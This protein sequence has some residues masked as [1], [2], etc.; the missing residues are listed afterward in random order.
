MDFAVRVFI[1]M[2]FSYV[3]SMGFAI[4]INVPRRA[5]NLSGVI[6]L[7]GWMIYWFTIHAG[8]GRM[9]SSF[10]GAFAVGILG[11]IF[12]RAKKCP[13]T[14]FNIPGL[15]PLVPG[16]AAYQAVRA[17]VDGKTFEAETAIL[18]VGIGTSAIALGILMSA[19]VLELIHKSK[20]VY[21]KRDDK[22]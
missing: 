15:V 18:R 13:V 3:A 6:G 4:T 17:L 12:A 14:V 22:L 8:M 11:S 16:M 9:L 19:M 5:L 21:K 1:N 2:L 10:L 20:K 7:V